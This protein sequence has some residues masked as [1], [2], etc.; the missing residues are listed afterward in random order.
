MACLTCINPY[1]LNP[2]LR[3][4]NKTRNLAIIEDGSTSF[5]LG[6]ELISEIIAYYNDIN[7]IK[8]GAMPY[9]IPSI[10]S[11]EDNSLPTIGYIIE[12]LNKLKSESI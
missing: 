8:I 12:N 4:F 9:P 5:G 10:R 2:I 1:N 3:L 11:L 7:F 6:S